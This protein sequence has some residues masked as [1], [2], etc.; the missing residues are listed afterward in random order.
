VSLAVG[1]GVQCRPNPVA[2]LLVIIII[3]IFYFLFF[4]IIIIIILL[5]FVDSGNRFMVD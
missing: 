3:I 1:E 4:F 5:F 2:T